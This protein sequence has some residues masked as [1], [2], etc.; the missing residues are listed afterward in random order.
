MW[1]S[2]TNKP[3]VI[4]KLINKKENLW[5]IS[6]ICRKFPIKSINTFLHIPYTIDPPEHELITDKMKYEYLNY[7]LLAK[8][9]WTII[10]D[11]DYR[12]IR[13]HCQKCDPNKDINLYFAWNWMKPD[14]EPVVNDFQDMMDLYDEILKRYL[15]SNNHNHNQWVD[16]MI[17]NSCI[18]GLSKTTH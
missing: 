18:D 13:S 15:V 12:F 9:Y 7:I 6:Y 14:P 1:A 10:Y 3:F 4:K 8:K 11:G 2:E 17:Y 16:E 5:E